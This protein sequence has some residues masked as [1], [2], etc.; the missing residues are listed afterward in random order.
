MKKIKFTSI[1]SNLTFWFLI[2]GLLPLF[3]GI[4]I[5]YNQQAN[6]IEHATFHKLVAIRDLKVQLLEN[7]L[8]ERMA[9]L[10]TSSKDRELVDLEDIIFK[11]HKTQSDLKTY[12]NIHRILNSYL[13]YYD[14]Y[15]EYFI[16]NPQTGLV[17]I[18]TRHDSEGMNVSDNIYFTETLK[19]KELFI[20]NIHYAKF[21]A[22]NSMTFSIPIFCAKHDPPHIIGIMVARIDLKNSL[23]PLLLNRVGLGNTGE[24][25]IV[26]QDMVALNE[27]RWYKNAPLNL[28]IKAEPAVNAA[29]GKTGITKTTD[30]RGQEILAAYTFIPETKW[31]FIC[32]Q[33]MSELNAPISELLRN[34]SILFIMAAIV[35][36]LIVFRISKV[37]S[38]PIVDMRMTS[39]RIVAGDYTIRNV[40]RS[41]DELGHLAQSFNKMTDSIVSKLVI[42]QG[43]SDITESMMA[44]AHLRDFGKYLLEK[45]VKIT[46]SDLGAFYLRNEENNL[47]EHFVSIGASSELP[48]VFDAEKLEGEFGRVLSTQKIAHI[49]D[50]PKDTVFTFKTFVGLS[51]PKE[52]ITIP[53][54]VDEKVMAVISLA[55]HK[56]YSKESLEIFN[57]T[58][59]A[60]NTG[61]ANQLSIAKTQKLTKELSLRNEQL[62]KQTQELQS[63][64]FE[65]QQRS[66]ELKE[67]NVQLEIQRQKTEQANRLKDEFLSNMSHELRTPLNSV[68]A[69]SR[70]LITQT[71]NMLSKEERNYL[72]IIERNGKNLLSL[73]NDIL[74]VSKIEAGKMDIAL[75][76]FP[77]SSIIETILERVEP[78]AKEKGLKIIRNIPDNL[79]PLES[80]RTKVNQ[81][82]QNLIGNAVKFTHQGSITV[83]ASFDS[84]KIYIEVKDTG[85]G[86]AEKDLPDIFKEFIQVD[87]SLSRPYGGTGLGLAIAL[88]IARLLDGD[89]FV[90]SSPGKGSNFTL[91]LPIKWSGPIPAATKPAAEAPAFKIQGRS[92]T[93]LIIDDDPKVCNTIAGYLAQEGY[94]TLTAESGEEGLE[95]AKLHHPFAITLDM[96]MPKPDG[97]EVL[98][99][100][101]KT[102]E[103]ADIPVII[104]SISDDKNTGFAFGAIG[105]INKPFN[106]N[107]LIAEI[108]KVHKML[109]YSVMVVDDNRIDRENMAGI[110]EQENIKT[111]AADS[112]QKCME[113][114]KKSVPD[115]LVLDLIMPVMDGFEVLDKLRKSPQTSDLPVIV[116]TAKD[117]SQEDKEKLRANVSSIL[118]KSDTTSS[119]LLEEIKKVLTELEQRAGYIR[120]EAPETKKVLTELEQSAGY[121]REKAPEIKGKREQYTILLVEDN[122]DNMLVLEALLKNK[123]KTLEAKDGEEGLRTTLTQLPDLVLLDMS[124]P[125]MDG[126][127]VVRKIK[128]D[129]KAGHIPVIALTAHA[130]AG[131][132]KKTIEAGCD[133][134]ISK[135]IDPEQLLEDLE[136]WLGS[137]LD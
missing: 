102:P 123:Y 33:D 11:E 49:K 115:I 119:A 36:F 137:G 23:Y 94:Y 15:H 72:E 69:L 79:P 38:K 120:E 34:L 116:V 13:K 25:L 101:K 117:L 113:L 134:Y 127:T 59:S 14:A 22:R 118:A 18:S 35:I 87:G 125:K 56:E 20:K 55:A 40:V 80:D 61:L 126:F 121:I 97:W 16:I 103:T 99:L 50:I 108:Y 51:V 122:P 57:Q 76:C 62:E 88:K 90:E 19:T 2:L 105:Y 107:D 130:M 109:P 91:A 58:R 9:D 65:L 114:I 64:K 132:R 135:P 74:D 30:Y 93:I 28:K 70:V 26:N 112:G 24:T 5:T 71:K 84:Q 17:E 1:R 32:K 8:A 4:L 52:I 78:L 133:D 7:W 81:I 75:A 98:Q 128:E 67:Q 83:S 85:I 29:R 21:L 95:L 77:P 41:R 129:K 73:I 42:R 131:D 89:I 96:I 46:G 82:L 124:L 60:M 12:E 45:L 3:I 39:Q 106:K 48:P 31:G 104:V 100:L 92:K 10:K 86:I 111:V 47:F 37:I 53:I 6:S 68:M 44:A 136:K 63:R 27:L 54:M 110:L 43:N 66:D